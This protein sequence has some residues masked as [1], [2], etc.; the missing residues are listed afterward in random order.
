MGY[1]VSAVLSHAPRPFPVS[2]RNFPKLI[3][4]G[5]RKA[6]STLIKELAIFT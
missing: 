2:G 5:G 4:N 1:R 3:I 6:A